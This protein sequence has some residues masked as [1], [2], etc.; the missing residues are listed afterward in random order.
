MTK[1][2][3]LST[4]LLFM[5]SAGI[6]LAQTIQVTGV[7]TDA[8]DGQ[9]LPGTAIMIKGGKTGAYSD[10]DGKYSISCAPNTTFIVSYIGYQT[11]EVSINGRSIVNIQMSTAN[12]LDEVIVTALGVT[13]QKKALGYAVQDVKGDELTKVRT[14]NVISSLSGRVAGVQ[15]TTATGQMGGGAKINIRG[16]TSL[17]GNNQP[18][19]VVDGIPISN[20]DFSTNPT[21]AG[22]GGYDLGNFASDINPD[23]V[24]SMT[25]LKGASASAL[26]GS[27]AANGVVLVTTKKA[28]KE[29]KSWGV[30]VNSS[31]TFDK[32]AYMP[33]YQKEYGGGLSYY[34]APG[35]Q[36]FL[37]ADIGGK[38]YNV[39]DYAND[40]SWGPKYDPTIKVLKWNAFDEWDTANYMKETPWV[41]PEHDYKSYYEL[42]TNLQNNFQISKAGEWG[43]FR[44]SYT[45]NR[46]TG[47]SPNSTMWKNTFNVS[48]SANFNKYIDGWATVNYSNTSA[49][50]RQETGYGERNPSQKMW[51]WIHTSLD[52]EEMK[53]YM[54]PDG[55]QRS[56]NRKSW[57]N[58][59]PN[60]TDNPY[61]T[62]N[63]NYESDKRNRLFGNTGL[64]VKFTDYLKLTGRVGLDWYDY[65]LE[66]RFAVGSCMQSKY[67]MYNRTQSELNLDLMLTFNKRVA[68]DKFGITAMLGTNS[69]V[70]NSGTSGG[71]T[72]NGLVLPDVYNLSNSASKADI[73]DYKEEKRINSILANVTL[74]YNQLIFLDITARND[75]SSTLPAANRSYFYPSFNLSFLLTSLEGLKNLKWMNFAK[76]RAGWAKVGND[77]NPYNIQSY[78]GSTSGGPFDG[79]PRYAPPTTMANSD[80]LPEQTKSWE[81]GLEAQFL[82]GRLGFDAAYYQKVTTDQI[83]PIQTSATIGYYKKYINAG[84]MSN[85]GF[86]L[87]INATPIKKKNFTWEL[88]L[89]IATLTNKVDEIADGLKYL[90][91]N[92]GAFRVKTGAF[93]GSSYPII[94]GT[95]FVYDDA[96]NKLIDPNS[97][98]YQSTAIKDIGSATPNFTAGLST[99]FKFY[100]V[101]VSLLFDM[102]RGGNMYYTSYMWGVYSGIFEE[103]AAFV[104]G[105]NIR[106]TGV[107]PEGVYGKMGKD[108][109]IIYLDAD[110]KTANT[111]V[112]ASKNVSALDYFAG[113]S[114]TVD[115]LNVFDTDFIKLREARIGYT[116]PNRWT[117]PIKDVRISAFGRNLAIFGRDNKHFDP[118]YLQVAGSNAQ[119]I[120]GG[121]IP[122]TRSFGVSLNFNF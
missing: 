97:G 87:T 109:K 90:E 54:N 83:V 37:T 20:Q 44:M 103:S 61:W 34:D 71:T 24:E 32:A 81:V 22:G 98:R 35:S 26:Y 60:F 52:Y 47:I 65:Q 6:V 111:P 9:P 115:K 49:T 55:T 14:P 19:F 63:K 46:I 121:Y 45:N 113:Y 64:N 66:Q 96:G 31:M 17:T 118:E 77:T 75:W 88:Q 119:G 39:V 73:F 29:N 102:Q 114:D 74:D 95:D 30:S 15:I 21:G 122:T 13:R 11:Q 12:A 62:T 89:N 101:D 38:T 84:K 57:K 69:M 58:P 92:N 70:L 18:L 112:T 41:Y 67:Y 48:G 94:Y 93:V 82:N 27:R 117:G 16:N 99:T 1:L 110:G 10:V 25:V 5:V 108:G 72:V 36:G 56:W 68:N 50:G 116:L 80:L 53:D 78:Y 106:E 51:Q 8:Q 42:G 100:G 23:D 3:L 43:A 104:D 76:I 91:L 85:K 4:V 33:E 120:E 107:I 105:K 28:S 2:R 7:V 86:E 79:N 40:M 59:A